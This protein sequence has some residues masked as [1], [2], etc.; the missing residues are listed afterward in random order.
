M[1]TRRPSPGRDRNPVDDEAL[2]P[3]EQLQPFRV[4][5]GALVLAGVV[6]VIAVGY[7][8]L[9]GGSSGG[10]GSDEPTFDTERYLVREGD[11]FASLS[12]LLAV[13]ES[14]IADANGLSTSD[15]LSAGQ[16]LTIPS[17]PSPGATIPAGVDQAPDHD[18]TEQ[19]LER[20]ADEYGVPPELLKALAW[21]ESGW[22]NSRV[23]SAGAVGIG[24]LLPD[25]ATYVAQTL[26][27]EPT[28]SV[29]DPSDNIQMSARYL[30]DLLSLNQGDWAA[31]LASYN[32]GPTSVRR[33]GWNAEATQYVTD[34]MAI[35]RGFQ[36]Q[37]G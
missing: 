9:S 16:E 6:T 17:D 26:L 14:T 28:L 12:T 24:Q 7:L 1:S 8:L 15:A 10:G 4:S 25:T 30:A 32:Q 3:D 11:T 27:D 18:E 29:D 33:D 21:Q 31:S 34:V 5:K 36:A 37:A 20:W 22:D 2:L 13:D 35:T 23:S 19:L